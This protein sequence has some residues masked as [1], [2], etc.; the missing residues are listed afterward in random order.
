M[1]KFTVRKCENSEKWCVCVDGIPNPTLGL[2]N[3]REEAEAKARDECLREKVRFNEPNAQFEKPTSDSNQTYIGKVTTTID[4]IDGI[5]CGF[6]Q[7]LGRG[8][9]A[10]HSV[11]AP[12]LHNNTNIKVKYKNGQAVATIPDITKGKGIAD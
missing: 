11:N 8:K 3:T 1:P 10:L 12:E 5:G 7:S 4:F 2:F 9:Y 6:A